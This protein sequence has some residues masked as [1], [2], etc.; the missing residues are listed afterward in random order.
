MKLGANDGCTLH[1]SRAS[2]NGKLMTG[3]RD[4][5]SGIGDQVEPRDQVGFVIRALPDP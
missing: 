4:Q 5:G 3:I 1:R 2:Q